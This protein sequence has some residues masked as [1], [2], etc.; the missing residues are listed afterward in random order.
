MSWSLTSVIPNC[1]PPICPFFLWGSRW[2]RI[3]WSTIANYSNVFRRCLKF[4]K[5]LPRFL[6]SKVCNNYSVT[7]LL[8]SDVDCV[9]LKWCC[10]E[11]LAMFLYRRIIFYRQQRVCA[12]VPHA[13]NVIKLDWASSFTALLAAELQKGA[14]V[15]VKLICCVVVVVVVVAVVVFFFFKPIAVTSWRILLTRQVTKSI[16]LHFVDNNSWSVLDESRVHGTRK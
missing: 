9:A 15:F 5:P 6:G 2:P 1:K 10:K 3:Q 4:A 12:N 8:Y 11:S 13:V 7:T 16:F 14:G